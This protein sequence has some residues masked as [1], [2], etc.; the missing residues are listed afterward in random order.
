MKFY[1]TIQ[2]VNLHTAIVEKAL[3]FARAVVTTVDYS[4]CHQTKIK[5]VQFDHFISKLGEEA[6]ANVL[7]KYAVVQGPDYAVYEAKDKSWCED[8][9]VNNTGVAV[10]T[11]TRSAA[12]KYTL[13]WTFQHGEKRRDTIFNTPEAWVVFVE[14]N[15]LDHYRCFV[16][17]PFQLKELAFKAPKLLH[18]AAHK[19]V[20]YANT[21][22]L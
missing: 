8:L 15:D 7:S 1:T 12:N 18:L 3:N 5:K 10:K 11:Q 21:L 6:A 22:A 13:S 20:V 14:C 9:L 16:Y 2:E 4:D 17:P 19:K